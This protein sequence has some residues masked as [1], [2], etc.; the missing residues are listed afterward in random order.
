MPLIGLD[1]CPRQTLDDDDDDD[2]EDGEF[3]MGH[4]QDFGWGIIVNFQRRI[5]A[6]SQKGG[7]AEQQVPAGPRYTVDVLVHAAGSVDMAAVGKGNQASS[8]VS[9]A[10]L[11]ARWLSAV[12][13][14]MPKYL[15]PAGARNGLRCVLCEVLRRFSDYGP[16][17]LDPIQD[18][19]IRD[20]SFHWL[21]RRTEVLEA[22]LRESL[23]SA[24]KLDR[25]RERHMARSCGWPARWT[26][27]A[28]GC[29][30]SRACCS[31]T[32]SRRREPRAAAGGAAMVAT[33][34]AASG[35]GDVIG[36][37]GRVVCEV[38][39]G[40]ELVLTELLL[41]GA[42]GDLSVEQ[43]LALLSCFCH[44]EK[45]ESMAPLEEALAVPYRRLQAKSRHVARVSS[46]C[47]LAVDEQAYVASFRAELMPAR[48]AWARGTRF[49]DIC[50]LSD[51]YEGSL[52]RMFRML[53]EL[54]W[55]M[56]NAAKRIGNT[57]LEAKFAE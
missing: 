14:H 24:A 31:S 54:L 30:P 42:F 27:A 47:K 32:T 36:T 34:D 56:G 26:G 2:D 1:C 9:L 49:A 57:E 43:C 18:L 21:M 46:E 16:L 52:V 5:A 50:H 53:E 6:P 51:A 39:V 55:Q 45:E 28:S 10:Q 37:K 40:D 19:G 8:R 35:A 25:R 38:S 15:R 44:G 17:H 7:G 48:Y 23:L 12:K 4:K 41:D 13:V 29:A 20:D 3:G 33:G 22:H 11:M